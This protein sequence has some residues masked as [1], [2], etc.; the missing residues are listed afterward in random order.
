MVMG[1]FYR[2]KRAAHH[3]TSAFLGVLMV[4]VDGTQQRQTIYMPAANIVTFSNKRDEKSGAHLLLQCSAP[5][6][7]VEH[8]PSWAAEVTRELTSRSR[9]YPVGS[10]PVGFVWGMVVNTSRIDMPIKYC[11]TPCS[12]VDSC[13]QLVNCKRRS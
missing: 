13:C 10:G 4:P 1:Y 12:G 9:Y 3:T 8:E 11:I 6:C 2:K 5:P 7:R